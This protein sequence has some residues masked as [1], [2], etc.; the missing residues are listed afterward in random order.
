MEQCSFSNE[1]RFSVHP[2]NRC[3]FIWMDV[4]AVAVG[5]IL[6]SCTKSLRFGDGSVGRKESFNKMEWPAC[7]PDWNPI[8]HVWDALGR[9]VAGHQS[10]TQTLQEPERDVLEEWDRIPHNS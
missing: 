9:R 7:S 5:I 6:R 3:I 10:P 2:D 4:P 8:E 1:S